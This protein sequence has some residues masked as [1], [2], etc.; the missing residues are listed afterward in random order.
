MRSI[1]VGAAV[2][3]ALVMGTVCAAGALADEPGRADAA[4]G[5]A[6]A[7]VP[8]VPSVMSEDGAPVRKSLVRT[9]LGAGVFTVSAQRGRAEATVADL[10]LAGLL[11]ADAVRTWCADGQGG[12]E[13]VGGAVMGHPL[14][15]TPIGNDTVAVGPLV[16]VELNH[17]VTHEDGSLTVEGITVTVLPDAPSPTRVRSGVEQAALPGLDALGLRVPVAAETVGDVLAALPTSGVPIVIG[18][19]T[20][21]PLPRTAVENPVEGAPPAAP[22]PQVVT[23]HLPVTG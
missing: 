3:A 17:Q 5:F 14:P 9:A 23:A 22:K 13:I 2:A 19:A 20:C 21:N 18:S 12:L 4:Y 1:V 16:K 15:R 10:G 11:K 7:G 6:T 8:P